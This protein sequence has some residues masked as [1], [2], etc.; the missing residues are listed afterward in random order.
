MLELGP[1][2]LEPPQ[3]LAV[4]KKTSPYLILIRGRGCGRQT[5]KG[6]E[7]KADQEITYDRNLYLLLVIVSLLLGTIVRVYIILKLK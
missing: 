6:K 3:E 7:P 4:G 2:W 5:I 1:K